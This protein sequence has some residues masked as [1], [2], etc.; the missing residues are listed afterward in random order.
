MWGPTFCVEL[1]FLMLMGFWLVTTSPRLEQQKPRLV[2][3]EYHAFRRRRGFDAKRPLAHANQPVDEF[4]GLLAAFR[5]DFQRRVAPMILADVEE[6]V[7]RKF[8]LATTHIDLADDSAR[9]S[10]RVSMG[11]HRISIEWAPAGGFRV[12][13]VPTNDEPSHVLDPEQ[14]VQRVGVLL[15]RVGVK[16]NLTAAERE[17][18]C[19]FEAPAIE[20]DAPDVLASSTDMSNEQ[21]VAGIRPSPAA[22]TAGS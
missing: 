7:R 1:Q 11:E 3:D 13:R 16:A 14:A 5:E 22:R 9:H 18:F 17:R 2:F 21:P 20:A 6:D 19:N 4:M 12:A 8:P 15:R 10:L